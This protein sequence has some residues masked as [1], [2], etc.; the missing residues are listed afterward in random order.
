MSTF[1]DDM[2]ALLNPPTSSTHHATPGDLANVIDHRTVTTPALELIDQ[3]LVDLLNT[4]D[5]RLII[6]MPPQEGKSTRCSRD[7]PIWALLG[8]PDLR[9]V[10]ASY[11]QGLANRN[12]RAVRNAIGAH[13]ELGLR[14]ARDNGAVSEWTIDGRRGGVLSVGRGAGVTGRPADMLIIDD[15]LKDRAEADSETI[16]DTCWDWWTDA[17]SA[18]LAPGAP[19]LVILT[20][21]HE[22]D[23]AGRLIARDAAAGWKVLNISAQCEDADT[24]PLGRQ[25]GEFMQ[26]AQRRTLKQ[27]EQRKA[28]AGSRTWA[29]LYQGHPSPAEGGILKREWWQR[30]H[31]PQWVD[32]PDG[33]RWAEGFDE[34]ILSADLAFKGTATSDY[35]AIGVWGRRGTDAY[36]LDLDRRHLDFVSTVHAFT[37]MAKRWPQATLKLVED[38]ANGPAL[39]SMLSKR[40]Q[41]I[42]PVNP[43]ASKTARVHAWAPLLEARH[44]WIPSSELCPWVDDFVE[45]AAGFPNA[46]HDDSVDMTSQAVDRLLL[47]PFLADTTVED[48]EYDDYRIGY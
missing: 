33:T 43:T 44:I 40:V 32:R 6:T 22:D 37:A 18:R 31:T 1:L 36:L 20:R 21:W 34:I 29:A 4:P 41:G 15:P 30:Y 7:L 46:A 23:L 19:V 35:V 2:A 47:R 42:V 3:H 5:G 26:S 9:I 10:S 39:I 11:A 38:K 45:E 13:P 27:W 14:I 12:G 8:N 17:L 48:D 25:P 16:R 28:T 24:D